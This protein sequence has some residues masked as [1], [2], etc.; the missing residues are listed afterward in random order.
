MITM[1]EVNVGH[2]LLSDQSSLF[3]SM[4]GTRL[5][6]LS[7]KI[8]GTGGGRFK[9]MRGAYVVKRAVRLT[10]RNDNGNINRICEFVTADCGRCC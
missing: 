2:Y 8:G 4:N 1:M 7:F 9:K 5:Q 10:S 6:P 3:S